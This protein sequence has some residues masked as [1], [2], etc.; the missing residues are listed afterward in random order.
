V[1]DGFITIGAIGNDNEDIEFFEN[2]FNFIG[3]EDTLRICLA[4]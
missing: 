2:G 1:F 4:K 3:W